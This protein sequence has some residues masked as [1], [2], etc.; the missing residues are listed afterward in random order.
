VLE[1]QHMSLI[2]IKVCFNQE[3]GV[4]QLINTPNTGRY[5]V[6]RTLSNLTI[7]ECFGSDGTVI[8]IDDDPKI[9]DIQ[10]TDT[11]TLSNL[12]VKNIYSE[13]EAALKFQKGQ[14]T[15]IVLDNCT[16]ENNIGGDGPADIYIFRGSNITIESSVFK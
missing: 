7:T 12:V 8:Q 13:E 11:T 2:Q 4:F 6:T 9:V 14:N 15:N 3:G 10:L 5:S 16:F 1:K